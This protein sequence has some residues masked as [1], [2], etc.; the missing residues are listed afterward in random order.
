MKWKIFCRIRA[1]TYLFIHLSRVF[2]QLF[3]GVWKLSRLEYVPVTIFGGSRLEMD[4]IYARKAQALARKL[5]MSGVP[6]LSGGGPGIMEAA[7]CG[8]YKWQENIFSTMG[9]TVK[10]LDS[11]GES[12]NKCAKNSLV[13]EYFFT[14]KWLLVHYSRGFAVF[15]GGFGTLDELAEIL[16]LIQTNMKA[17]APIVLIGTEYWKFF[18]D[19]V[20]EALKQG[21]ISEEDVRLFT[22]TNDINYAHDLLNV[23]EPM[24]FKVN[25]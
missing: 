13:L 17:K 15:P 11:E 3:Y 4:S 19:W 8:A 12:V 1:F 20:D 14:R 6:V 5:A 21:L 9:I 23:H 24:D 22:V 7:N 10:G 25:P 16:T 2:G 18:L